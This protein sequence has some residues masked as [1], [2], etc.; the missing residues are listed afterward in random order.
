MVFPVSE[1][2]SQAT[3][4]SPKRESTNHGLSTMALFFCQPIHGSFAVWEGRKVTL[5]KALDVFV[6]HLGNTIDANPRRSLHERP[7]PNE[8]FF[9]ARRDRP[10]HVRARK[11]GK[12][13]ERTLLM[14]S[15]CMLDLVQQQE[16][17]LRFTVA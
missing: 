11:I 14:T 8:N 7:I 15:D 3:G 2:V 10:I 12:R 4:T 16:Y 13:E 9:H 5:R 6:I 1:I 17:F